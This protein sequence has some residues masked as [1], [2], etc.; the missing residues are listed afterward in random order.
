M[1]LDTIIFGDPHCGFDAVEDVAA[2]VD[3]ACPPTC[4][5]LGDFG[6]MDRDRSIRIPGQRPELYPLVDG[7]SADE[8]LRPLANL[9]CRI[10]HIRG[11]HDLDDE[12]QYGA[13]ISSRILNAGHLHLK[14]FEIGGVR[15]VG[16]DGV[17]GGPWNPDKEERGF[18]N[19]RT[20]ET[21]E[22]FVRFTN[23]YWHKDDPD[24]R[25]GP[26]L[27]KHPL[28]NEPGLQMG[29]RK[30][31]FPEDIEYLRG[32]RADILISHEAPQSPGLDEGFG[33]IGRV[34]EEIGARAVI[35]GHHHRDY[36]SETHEGIEVVGVGRRST[37][38]LD[39]ARYVDKRQ[40]AM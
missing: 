10:L 36:S 21:R 33:I 11:N 24:R 14:V 29:H 37:L 34:A 28:E 30:Y 6:F 16:L 26:K 8:I 2:E 25:K 13:V 12:A 35:H 1:E 9:G 18:A 32:L 23:G 22:E 4:I 19:S 40:P 17:F 3:P 20:A 5:F 31:I 27:F 15:I 7:R 39:L 38:R